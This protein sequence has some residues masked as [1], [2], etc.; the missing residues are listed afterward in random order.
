MPKAS[1]R[2][3]L[4]DLRLLAL[5]HIA[6][7]IFVTNHEN[8]IVYANREARSLTQR[9]WSDLDLVSIDALFVPDVGAGDGDNPQAR[10]QDRLLKT[11]EGS[12][13]VCVHFIDLPDSQGGRLGRVYTV[14][15]VRQ[16]KE[17]EHHKSG[18]LKPRGGSSGFG[19]IAGKSPSWRKV[20]EQI[21]MG[22]ASSASVLIVGEAGTGKEIIARA[23]HNESSRAGKPF[24]SVS[25]LSRGQLERALF[26]EGAERDGWVE[27]ANGGTLFLDEIGETSLEMQSELLR[28]LE[29][30]EFKRIN[31]EAVRKTDIRIIGATS[32]NLLAEGK[33][34]RF[35][36]DLYYRLS[37]LQ[38]ESP[39][40]RERKDDIPELAEHFLNEAAGDLGI[41]SLRLTR[42]HLDVLRSY[43]RPGNIR[44][45]QNVIERAVILCRHTG[46]LHFEPGI[47]GLS[48]ATKQPAA[49]SLRSF[50]V[51]E[52]EL[53][54][55]TLDQTGGKIYGPHGA[56]ALLAMRPTTLSSRLK[57]Y[58][59]PRPTRGPRLHSISPAAEEA[60]N[61]EVI[62]D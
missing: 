45:L 1:V 53:I 33:A 7:A 4:Q 38:I 8:C 52:R 30:G 22:G 58:G 37:L 41:S 26:G 55:R 43:T 16:E 13:R 35:L 31:N 47:S 61:E 5:E 9:V 51:Q 50:R 57:R 29:S 44:E 24:C 54:V 49:T 39:P 21:R 36:P 34:G 32:R 60:G 14:H 12:Q 15:P 48:D 56:A 10:S 42:R 6:D 11:K 59:V 18:P 2:Q 28:F 25:C 3:S 23:I 46:E 17:Y 19:S 40:L 62:L 20:L 27:L